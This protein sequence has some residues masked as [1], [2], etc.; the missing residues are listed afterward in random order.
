MKT[1]SVGNLLKG[2]GDL[3]RTHTKLIPLVTGALD[4]TQFTYKLA[5]RTG[6]GTEY[7]VLMLE[8]GPE[9]F[10]CT[11]WQGEFPTKFNTTCNDL[12]SFKV[13][14]EKLLKDEL[15]RNMI[16]Q[17]ITLGVS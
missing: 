5:V 4:G 1:H 17:L 16:T 15:T 9:A 3:L 13:E 11:L 10:P 6:M 14:L 7:T 2:I 12:E 8:H